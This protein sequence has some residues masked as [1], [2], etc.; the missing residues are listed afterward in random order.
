MFV[1][2]VAGGLA[3]LAPNKPAP[4]AKQAQIAEKA[5]PVQRPA[6]QKSGGMSARTHTIPR[7][8]TPAAIATPDKRKAKKRAGLPSCATVR[9]QYNSMTWPQR[10]AAYASATPE[11]IAHGRRCLGR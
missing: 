5:K 11:Q 10:M 6:A 2:A 3:F 4:V 1:A 9:A 7:P 8:R